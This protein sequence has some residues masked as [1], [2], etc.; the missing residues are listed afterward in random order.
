MIPVDH[1]ES[2]ENEIK[3][4]MQGSFIDIMKGINLT[5][6]I[7]KLDVYLNCHGNSFLIWYYY[8][9]RNEV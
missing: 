2:Y 5:C 4:I 6:L 8:T 9:P 1:T 3:I 7:D